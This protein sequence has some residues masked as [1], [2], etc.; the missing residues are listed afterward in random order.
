[1]AAILQTIYC[2]PC[3]WLTFI[4]VLT[5]A[6]VSYI[7]NSWVPYRGPL[8]TDGPLD[9]FDDKQTR[10]EYFDTVP[11]RVRTATLYSTIMLVIAIVGDLIAFIIL[12]GQ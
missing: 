5:F 9:G 4:A 11:L 8:P 1:M 2:I 6:G 3:L 10:I 12:N 7:R